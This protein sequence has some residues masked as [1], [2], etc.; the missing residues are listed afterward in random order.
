MV[1]PERAENVI[2]IPIFFFVVVIKSFSGQPNN[3]HTYRKTQHIIIIKKFTGTT[4]YLHI[5]IYLGCTCQVFFFM[6]IRVVHSVPRK[7]A[8][9]TQPAENK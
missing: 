5:Y 4:I 7:K 6:S 3:T 9:M 1:V 2:L 8:Q